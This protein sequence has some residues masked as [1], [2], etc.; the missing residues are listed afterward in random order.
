MCDVCSDI[1]T[2]VGYCGT[3]IVIVHSSDSTKRVRA[4][5]NVVSIVVKN[6]PT[7]P[8]HECI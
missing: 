6:K 5:R 4:H 7:F 8:R 2:H 3:T 1:S